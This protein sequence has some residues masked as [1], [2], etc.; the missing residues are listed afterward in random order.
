MAS[1]RLPAG[2][3]VT[4]TLAVIQ[5]ITQIDLVHGLRL[6]LG[7]HGAADGHDDGDDAILGGAPAQ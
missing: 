3:W 2:F 6:F 5:R 7:D 1:L 4:A